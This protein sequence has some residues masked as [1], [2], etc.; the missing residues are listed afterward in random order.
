MLYSFAVFYRINPITIFWKGVIMQFLKLALL[1]SVITNSAGIFA[2]NTIENFDEARHRSFVEDLMEKEKS[3]FPESYSK[4]DLTCENYELPFPDVLKRSYPER[5]DIKFK[6]Q[7]IY[8]MSVDEKPVGFIRTWVLDGWGSI[9]QL[10]IDEQYRN[11]GFAKKLLDYVL[12]DFQ[13]EGITNIV[14]DPIVQ[15]ESVNKLFES[16]GFM[17]QLVDTVGR[18]IYTKISN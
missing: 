7:R 4:I 17:K 12:E 6:R 9:P 18:T 3:S 14:A 10:M 16:A 8:M 5:S 13:S 2:A 11:Q 15:Y 1:L